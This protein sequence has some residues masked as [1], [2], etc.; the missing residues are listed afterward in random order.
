MN[1]DRVTNRLVKLCNRHG[2]D[3]KKGSCSRREETAIIW[4]MT[5]DNPM[6][7]MHDDVQL[8][9]FSAAD[10]VILSLCISHDNKYV[11]GPSMEDCN[12]ISLN[13]TSY[14]T[15]H[16]SSDQSQCIDSGSD[17][18]KLPPCLHPGVN[19]RF[20]MTASTSTVQTMLHVS[21]D[22]KRVVPKKHDDFS[23]SLCYIRVRNS[24]WVLSVALLGG[25]T[26]VKCY[27]C[28]QWYLEMPTYI[29]I[30]SMISFI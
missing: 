9:M 21:K 11:E 7:T 24:I 16:G 4:Q 22:K 14:V 30:R 29:H 12:I 20:K 28:I 25:L 6:M 2:F 15:H 8:V 26:L 5:I 3:I 10:Y 1:P 27:S 19:H 18:I 17:S 13:V 23:D